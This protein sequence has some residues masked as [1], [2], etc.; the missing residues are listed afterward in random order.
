MEWRR[1]LS[2]LYIYIYLYI[3]LPTYLPI[4]LYIYVFIITIEIYEDLK[5]QDLFKE[6]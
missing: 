1:E 6:V 5:I 3:Y 2:E 4:Y